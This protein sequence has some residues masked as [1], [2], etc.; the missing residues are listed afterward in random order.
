MQCIYFFRVQICL[1]SVW[2]ISLG[3]GLGL[4][5]EWP[6]V[7]THPASRGLLLLLEKICA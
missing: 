4:V 5:N 2:S 3:L 6:D 1:W 7:F